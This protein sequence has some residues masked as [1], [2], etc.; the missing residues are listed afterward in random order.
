M[1]ISTLRQK[2]ALILALLLVPAAL[3]LLL[4]LILKKDPIDRASTQ[5]ATLDYQ[6]N[7]KSVVA[8]WQGARREAATTGEIAS[9]SWKELQTAV[10]AAFGTVDR[11]N[12][13]WGSTLGVSNA[14]AELKEKWRGFRPGLPPEQIYESLNELIDDAL[15]ID[16]RLT[17]VGGWTLDTSVPNALGQT[18][19]S[20]LSGAVE[21]VARARDRAAIATRINPQ[22]D[23]AV[24]VD[25][26]SLR[27]SL[28]R[29]TDDFSSLVQ[30]NPS[31]AA[32]L[33]PSFA[34]FT[35]GGRRGGTLGKADQF[36][37]SLT[38][39][40]ADP[41][42]D[43]KAAEAVAAGLEAQKGLR[44]ALRESVTLFQ[45]KQRYQLFIL[46]GAVL[47]GLTLTLAPPIYLIGRPM[48]AQVQ[49]IVNTLDEIG[50]GSFESRARI[51]TQDELA[52]V[53]ESINSMLNNFNNLI[54]SQSE[55]DDIQ[56]A[57]QKLMSEVADVASGDL[58]VEAEVTN[59][60]TGSLADAINFMISQLRA[61][62]SNVQQAT[63]QVSQSAND[64]M[65][66][67]EHLSRGGDAQATQ[68]METSEAIDEI[69][70][71]IQQVADN[72]TQSLSVAEQ[73]RINARKGTEAVRDT[74]NGMD[75]IRDQVQET[76]K[77]IK[78][79]GESSQEIGDIVKLIGDIADRTSI[80]ALNASIQAAM[81]G[82]AGRGFAVVA[83]EVERLAERSN[84][85]TR[86]IATLIKTIQTVTAEAVA[87]MEESTRE[88]VEGSNLALTA[89]QALS[90]IDQVSNKLAEII[91]A[92]A[93]S[94]KQQ[95]R[96]SEALSKAMGQISVVTQQTAA[97]TREAAKSVSHLAR[98]AD[99]LRNSV[100]TF[101][102]PPRDG[103][104]PA[105]FGSTMA[106]ALPTST[107]VRSVNG[108]S[109]S[110]ISVPSGSETGYSQFNQRVSVTR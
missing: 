73:A 83:E 42:R 80:L 41:A 5:L 59:D 51:Y 4:T 11:Q 87:A 23:L 13:S 109:G 78:R 97:G 63:L 105:G 61:I 55:R 67:T 8:L 38:T 82:E 76:A 79:L 71:S 16:R 40:G 96:G 45:E 53:A 44:Q 47:I 39:G 17:A 100:S 24:L 52:R 56:G 77:R 27:G 28:A 10:E 7:L 70:A 50:R 66:T 91:Q 29:V 2:L 86:K 26:G 64:I 85:A 32:D 25:L 106:P 35:G 43:T 68:I 18:T 49:E 81:A 22:A 90:E 57:I 108:V 37:A 89:G 46:T 19:L 33:G 12:A 98:L 104:S 69:A 72:A 6:E 54:Q 58:T 15:A 102:L 9:G 103:S 1:S 3:L 74:I 95:A 14:W 75:R 62:V 34:V 30:G 36:V 60:F 88:V 94:V 99:D 110:S 92:I 20:D 31:L 93:F 84:E 107:R 101:K 21:A 48:L 65:V